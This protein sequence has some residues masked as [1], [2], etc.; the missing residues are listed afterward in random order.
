MIS[1]YGWRGAAGCARRSRAAARTTA[2]A[3]L[4]DGAAGAGDRRARPDRVPRHQPDRGLGLD[5]D[6]AYPG[7]DPAEARLRR[8]AVRGGER[9]GERRDVRRRPAADRLAAAA[10]GR[11]AGDRDRRER[12][13]SRAWRWTRCAPTSRRSSTRPGEQ[14]PKPA[15]VLVGHA[16]AAQPRLRLLPAVRGGLRRAGR[17][18]RPAAGA[19][20]PRGCGRR[21]PRSTRRT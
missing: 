8:A 6:Q 10:A 3:G 15:I 19:V 20:P 17:G 7:A 21:S 18:E 13:A 11:G 14:S 1:R 2:R 4:D 9:G 12:R 5:P 16:R